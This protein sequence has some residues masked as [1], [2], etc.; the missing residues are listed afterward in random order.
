MAGS[1][2]HI[3]LALLTVALTFSLATTFFPFSASHAKP[4]ST[5]ISF[6]A[7]L[8]SYYRLPQKEIAARLLLSCASQIQIVNIYCENLALV[9]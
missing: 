6:H 9:F 5:H 4:S 1:C 7:R 2:L 3:E 8:G